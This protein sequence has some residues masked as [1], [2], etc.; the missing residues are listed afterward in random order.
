M[1]SK[2]NGQCKS[3][4]A[5]IPSA[6]PLALPR[7]PP[8]PL[9]MMLPTIRAQLGLQQQARCRGNRV[10]AQ[11]SPLFAEKTLS[12]AVFYTYK[13]HEFVLTRGLATAYGI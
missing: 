9:K 3:G 1:K 2:L 13:C 10:L 6:T 8:K 7:G 5:V 11:Q 4:G 12:L